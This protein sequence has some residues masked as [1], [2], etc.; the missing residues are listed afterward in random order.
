MEV[1]VGRA[2]HVEA[3][4][5]AMTAK[6][7]NRADR[8]GDTGVTVGAAPR[9]RRE[10]RDGRRLRDDGPRHEQQHRDNGENRCPRLHRSNLLKDGRDPGGR[11]IAISQENESHEQNPPRG[12]P[13]SFARQSAT[14]RHSPAS[15]GAG[16]PWKEW[17]A[18][19]TAGRPGLL[20]ARTWHG[21]DE[22]C[23]LCRFIHLDEVSSTWHKKQLGP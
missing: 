7:Q 4:R 19:K 1:D 17:H 8:V 18:V 14:G 12:D 22:P 11:E 5:I 10:G 6:A 20:V 16:R 15:A 21:K 3:H 9:A 23:H 2:V 13:V